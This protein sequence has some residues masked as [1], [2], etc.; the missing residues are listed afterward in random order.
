[1]LPVFPDFKKIE[2]TDLE[3]I[4]NLNKHFPPFNDF[5]FMS[6][7]TYNSEDKN[8]ITTLHNNFVIRIHDFITGIYFYSFIGTNKVSE[9]ISTLIERSKEENLEPILKLIPEA[10]IAALP[11]I[12]HNFL[13]TE[14]PNSA[15]YILSVDK[16][17]SL[18]GS[19]YHDKRNL[20]NRFKRE[21]PNYQT[22]TLDLTSEKVKSEI[23]ALFLLWQVQK[24]K[25]NEECAIEL[26]AI[27]RLFD[28]TTALYL[29]GIGI[30]TN[31]NLVGF[32]ICH[33]VKEDFVILSFEKGDITFKGIYETIN[34]EAAKHLQSL[35]IKYI[36]YEQDL[37]I[38]GLRRSKMLWRPVSFLKKYT[39]SEKSYELTK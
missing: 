3:D 19:E 34:H 22:R 21:N 16:I 10:N 33:K 25:A 9:T 11:E 36:N 38:E 13:L 17:A 24:K 29:M 14:D 8:L 37:G 32:S 7:W 39:I 23:R 20:V 30:Y 27:N 6:L 28:L 18:K 35:G 4:E 1:M 5:E 2:L 31:E 26:N 15:E 12:N